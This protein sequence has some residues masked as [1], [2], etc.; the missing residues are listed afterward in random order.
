MRIVLALAAAAGLFASASAHA[1]IIE[2]TSA[3]ATSVPGGYRFTQGDIVL[4]ITGGLFTSGGLVTPG[5]QNARPHAYSI[6]LGESNDGDTEHTIDGNGDYEVLILAFNKTVQITGFVFS[7]FDGTDEFD[8]FFDSNN[9][10]ALNRVLDEVNIP[11]SGLALI[12]SMFNT[13]GKWFGVGADGTDSFK[14]KAVNYTTV[15]PLPAAFPLFLAGA[16][17]IGFA[18]RKRKVRA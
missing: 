11:N 14:L 7:Y 12:S 15:V 2:T 18:S 16:A 3:T 10:G 6:G 9:D 1:A 8:F 17:A 13:P 4:T 5:A